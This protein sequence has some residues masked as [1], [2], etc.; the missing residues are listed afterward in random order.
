MTSAPVY[1]NLSE[2]HI[3]TMKLRLTNHSSKHIKLKMLSTKAATKRRIVNHFSM[4]V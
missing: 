2:I 3:N 4:N 1:V